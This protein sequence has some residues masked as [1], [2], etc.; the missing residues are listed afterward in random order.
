MATTAS[1]STIVSTTPLQTPKKHSKM[2]NSVLLEW[3]IQGEKVDPGSTCVWKCRYDVW[4]RSD[5]EGSFLAVKQSN[6]SPGHAWPK[7]GKVQYEDVK[8]LWTKSAWFEGE[9]GKIKKAIGGNK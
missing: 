5:L 2:A 7:N 4:Y 9:M 6:P 3:E 1:T 8:Q